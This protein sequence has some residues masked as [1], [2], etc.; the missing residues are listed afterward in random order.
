MA[1]TL[2]RAPTSN[3]GQSKLQDCA[4]AL[5]EVSI[6]QLPASNGNWIGIKSHKLQTLSVLLEWL[7]RQKE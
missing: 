5:L 3:S 2:S 1:D 6:P 7:D 4:D